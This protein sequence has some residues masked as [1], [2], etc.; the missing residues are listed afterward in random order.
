MLAEVS[1]ALL[2]LY[3]G[4]KAKKCEQNPE[5]DDLKEEAW[6][7]FSW[8]LDTKYASFIHSFIHSLCGLI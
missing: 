5:L 8:S 7:G 1:A 6:P 2:Q 4:E 3:N